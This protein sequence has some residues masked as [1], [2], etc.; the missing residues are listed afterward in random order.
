MLIF[1]WIP[2]LFQQ[3]SFMKLSRFLPNFRGIRPLPSLYLSLS[4]SLSFHLCVESCLCNIY[5]YI[6]EHRN[7]CHLRHFWS[8]ASFTDTL[9]VYSLLHNLLYNLRRHPRCI[10]RYT[11]KLRIAW[12]TCMH[13]FVRLSRASAFFFSPFH[14][15]RKLLNARLVGRTDLVWRLPECW[16]WQIWQLRGSIFGGW[17]GGRMWCPFGV[18]S[19]YAT[20]LCGWL[21]TKI[22]QIMMTHCRF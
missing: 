8:A 9:C 4:L 13:T 21:K 7:A 10:P 1:M 2:E 16:C 11:Y 20:D 6:S 22:D 12:P 18:P 15:W 5:I 14:F 19:R 17:K 3:F